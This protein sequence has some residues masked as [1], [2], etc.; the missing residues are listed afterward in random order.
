M[1]IK[2][3]QQLRILSAYLLLFIEKYKNARADGD[4]CYIFKLSG[5]RLLT[6]LAENN[7]D[8]GYQELD[9]EDT[10]FLLLLLVI[11]KK[12][13]DN[14]QVTDMPSFVVYRDRDSSDSVLSGNQ[15]TI[16]DSNVLEETVERLFD[17]DVL[18]RLQYFFSG[19]ESRSFLKEELAVLCELQAESFCLESYIDELIGQAQK[20][21]K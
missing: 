11:F 4:L 18:D 3:T 1:S 20:V 2:I 16:F 8:E 9:F 19:T 10:C 17:E 12:E 21:S 15:I 5:I 13:Y 7:F 14:D 6:N